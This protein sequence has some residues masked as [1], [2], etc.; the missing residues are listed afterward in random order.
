MDLGLEHPDDGITGLL[1][2]KTEKE[3]CTI[4]SS[5]T[6]EAL[7]LASRVGALI[8]ITTI[9]MGFYQ[10]AAHPAT[11]TL[12][13]DKGNLGTEVLNKTA[14]VC[15]KLSGIQITKLTID[16]ASEEGVGEQL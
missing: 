6:K 12:H 16:P 15:I 10:G 5:L 4:V 3:T 11:S 9:I 14:Y 13:I 1:A 2:W 8:L 7:R